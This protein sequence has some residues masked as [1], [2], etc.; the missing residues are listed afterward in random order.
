MTA[1]KKKGIG[2]LVS[3][4]AFLVGGGIFLGVD[5]TPDWL[6]TVFGIIGMVGNALGFGTVFPDTED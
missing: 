2:F 4:I 5:V 1:R 6:G 3:G